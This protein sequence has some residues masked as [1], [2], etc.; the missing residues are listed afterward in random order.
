M[1]K[2]WARFVVLLSVLG[3]SVAAVAYAEVVQNV[4][5]P[6]VATFFIPCANDTVDFSGDLHVVISFTINGN[7]VSGRTQY[8]P[9]G[10]K[11]IGR[12]TGTR[13]NAVGV[14]QDMLHGSLQNGQFNETLVNNFRL[15]GQGPG[16][17]LVVHQNLHVT[18]NANGDV[19][20]TVDNTRVDCK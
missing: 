4:Q 1:M 12:A 20:A 14:T 11:G 17:N 15:I 3:L 8:Q 2:K 18:I 13:Y 10:I 19:T 5:M 16:N 6:F 9:Q 7:E